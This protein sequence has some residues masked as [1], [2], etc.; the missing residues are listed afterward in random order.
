MLELGLCSSSTLLSNLLNS[1][2]STDLLQTVL[3]SE[4]M[5]LCVHVCMFQLC[6]HVC[7]SLFGTFLYCYGQQ[8]FCTPVLSLLGEMANSELATANECTDVQMLASQA[9][10]M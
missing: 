1:M 3:L 10:T 5:L 7:E 4:G 2:P 8:G 9:P 6:V